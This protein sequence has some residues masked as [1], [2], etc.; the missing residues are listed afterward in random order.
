MEGV[1]IWADPEVPALNECL[2]T[3]RE[4]EIERLQCFVERLGVMRL[5]NLYGAVAFAMVLLG[6]G[7]G[8]VECCVVFVQDGADF[9]CEGRFSGGAD[10]FV[11]VEQVA[12]DA[13]HS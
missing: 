9:F 7:D 11:L 5:A 12:K 10:E 3:E 6:L 13:A 2:L 4:M 1:Q 8:V